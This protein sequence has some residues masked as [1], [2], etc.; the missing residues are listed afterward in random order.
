M[1]G[2]PFTPIDV[3][4]SSLREVWDLRGQA[5]LD[6]NQINNQRLAAFHQLDLRIDKR[7]FFDRWNLNWYFDVQNAY[8]FKA[9]QPPLL[10]PQREANG[11]IKID[12]NDPTRYQMR[13]VD[14][15]AGTI[16]PTV[17]IIVE[18]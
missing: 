13:L 9:Q 17:G 4:N 1:G 15:P 5:T 11:Q 6:F 3:E 10:V 2:L 16:L 18:F 14:N 8:N 7:Y 12:P